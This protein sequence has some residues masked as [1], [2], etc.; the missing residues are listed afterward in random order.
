MYSNRIFGLFVVFLFAMNSSAQSDSLILNNN[1]VII[2][3]IKSMNR[4]VVVIETDY[5]DSDFKIEWEGIKEIYTEQIFI[6]NV[7]GGKLYTG[8]IESTSPDIVNIL[9]DE[10]KYNIHMDSIIYLNKYGKD[11]LSNFYASIGLGLNLTKTNNFTQFSLNLSAGYLAEKWSL[12]LYLN[13]L[14]STQAEIEDIKRTDAGLEY[15]F[16][17]PKNW[18]LAV[19][20]DFLS[21]TE[22]AITLRTNGRLGAGYFP[23]KN[24]KLYWGFSAGGNTNLENFS[25]DTPDR[26]SFEAYIGSEINLFNISDFSLLS[27]VYVFP[28]LTEAGRLRVDYTLNTKYDLPLDF[29]IGLNFS[30]NYDNRP[31]EIGKETD[32]VFGA[33][34]GWSW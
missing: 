3:E 30:L 34:F 21:N 31:A 26:Q 32:Y 14:N 2:G 24:N 8:R 10:G 16:L 27:N 29:Y 28:S 33:S 17:L 15:R 18:Y 13:N 22:Q 20:A 7:V 6:I 23:I 5:S 25:N 19:A 11:F 9:G 1:N 4:S 12:D